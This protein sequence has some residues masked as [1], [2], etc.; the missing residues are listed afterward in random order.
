MNSI[1]ITI[2]LPP[3]ECRP[4]GS[5]GHWAQK[6]KAKKAYRRKVHLITLEAIG[7]GIPERWVKA[8]VNIK[9]YFKTARHLDP[10]NLVA[11]LKSALDGIADAGVVANDK[12]LW[13]ERP[14]IYKDAKNPRIEL[15]VT[16]E[17]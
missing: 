16:E 14:E 7:K 4:N 6:A 17:E 5:H 11:S 15:T 3:K 10:D 8:K 12:G 13:P 9:A 2:P 1:T